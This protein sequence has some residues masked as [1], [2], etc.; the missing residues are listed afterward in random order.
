MRRTLLLATALLVAAP[1]IFAQDK[2]SWTLQ[3][4]LA[5]IENSTQKSSSFV[6]TT[7]LKAT[8]GVALFVRG[9]IQKIKALTESLGGVYKYGANNY[10]AIYIPLNQIR[11]MATSDD[12]SLLDEVPGTGQKMNDQ[13]LIN[14]NVSP[15]HRGDAPLPGAYDGTGVVVGIID[16]GIDF[17]HADFKK[18]DGTTRIKF[19]WDMGV[20][21]CMGSRTPQPYNYGVE[22]NSAD[23]DSGLCTHVDC[24]SHGSHVAG[25]AAGNGRAVNNFS[26]VAPGSDI[27]AV[28][29]AGYS[30]IYTGVSTCANDTVYWLTMVTDAIN[31]IFDK[32]DSMG[33]PCVINASVGTYEVSTSAGSRDGKDAASQLITG[34][35][36]AQDGRVF[37]ASAGNWGGGHQSPSCGIR[38][39]CRY[40]V[41]L[42]SVQQW[43]RVRKLCK[44]P[45]SGWRNG[46]LSMG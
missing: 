29:V 24:D 16:S 4:Q 1:T 41:L 11:A 18:A 33:K 2:I 12:V 37:V 46:L 21:S 8:R 45:L 10:S 42:V 6:P 27:I 15:V 39:W 40:Y 32:A 35:L 36:N 25:I 38:Y 9:D 22:W 7:P 3:K 17:S 43:G 44:R 14:N 13:V 31:Y 5:E 34:L 23:I 28:S 19:I 26:G 30:C 20:D